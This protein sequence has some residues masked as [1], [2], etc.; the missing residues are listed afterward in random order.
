MAFERQGSLLF[1]VVHNFHNSDMIFYEWEMGAMVL[2][3]LTEGH[4]PALLPTCPWSLFQGCRHLS[5][6]LKRPQL[7]KRN[8]L[9]D[10]SNE[11]AKGGPMTFRLSSMPGFSPPG[12]RNLVTRRWLTGSWGRSS[13]GLTQESMGTPGP[14]PSALQMFSGGSLSPPLPHRGRGL[15]VGE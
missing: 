10:P 14:D 4:G 12:Q 8:S 15:M 5:E 6:T 11:V 2:W 13:L 7:L 3:P 9:K 1:C